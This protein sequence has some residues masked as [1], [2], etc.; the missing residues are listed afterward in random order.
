VTEIFTPVTNG[1]LHQG[2]LLSDIMQPSTDDGKTFV[3]IKH[4][5][6]L[7]LSQ[8]CDLDW[9][10]NAHRGA[11]ANSNKLLKN[12]ILCSAYEVANIRQAHD[13]NSNLF[14]PIQQNKSERYQYLEACAAEFDSQSVGVPA[15]VCD[16]K[17]Y[18]TLSRD[19]LYHQVQADPRKRRS[20]LNG[21]YVDHL[22]DR[23]ANYLSRIALP[24]QH[25]SSH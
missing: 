3:E 4:S 16:F 21:P 23:F 11:E 7:L 8:E 18:F 10:F 25:G 9:D 19:H 22:S 1:A 14:R 13:L 17:Y 20:R 24:R 5:F 12:V 6:C 2:E 15:L